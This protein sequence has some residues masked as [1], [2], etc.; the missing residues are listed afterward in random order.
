MFFSR[1]AAGRTAPSSSA[2]AASLTLLLALSTALAS[3]GGDPPGNEEYVLRWSDEFEQDGSP[4][5]DN[6]GFE[7]GFVRNHEAQWYQPE[8]AWCEKGRLIIEAR[9]ETRKVEPAA[10]GR[11]VPAWVRQRTQAEYTSAS[12]NTRG[13]RSWLYGRF[14][15]R[16]R[17][18]AVQ[19]AWPAFWTLGEGRWPAC[20]EIDVMEY[21]DDS[22][23]ANAAWLGEGGRP[24]W[25]A[26]KRPLA[27]FGDR[28]WSQSFHVYRMDWDAGSIRL[29]VDDE[30]V[31]AIDTRAVRNADEDGANPFR[32]PHYLLLNLAVAG[33]HGGDPSDTPFPVR[34][35]ID[36][37]R[38][39]QQ[40]GAPKVVSLTKD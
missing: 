1:G 28:S 11:G 38:V 18:P 8:N 3:E 36:Y 31:N 12:L 24:Q 23:L 40:A 9:R 6:W 19:G 10:S 14:V 27:D 32:R 15:M 7:S 13:K 17:I 39:Y 37:V 34:Y 2:L 25:D 29:Y 4:S 35:E 26:S 22:L 16:A 30:L 33:V 5:A 21:Y 20:G